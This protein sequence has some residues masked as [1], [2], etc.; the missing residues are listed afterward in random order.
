MNQN[1]FNMGLTEFDLLPPEEQVK[2][3]QSAL[4]DMTN[5]AIRIL[6]DKPVRNFDEKIVYSKSL[7][8]T[9]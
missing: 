8:E 6:Q 1:D 9:K 3:L 5:T 2:V 4:K 7:Y